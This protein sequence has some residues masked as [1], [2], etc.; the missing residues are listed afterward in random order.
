MNVTEIGVEELIQSYI[1]VHETVKYCKV[2]LWRN[3]KM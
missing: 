1:I 2:C 3:L